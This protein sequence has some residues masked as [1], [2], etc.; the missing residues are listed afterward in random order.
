MDGS[1]GSRAAPTYLAVEEVGEELDD[2]GDAGGAA[3]E[4]DVVDLVLGHLGVTEDLLDRLHL[5]GGRVMEAVRVSVH[6]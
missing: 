5:H 3:D 4:D 1:R 2:L 6:S